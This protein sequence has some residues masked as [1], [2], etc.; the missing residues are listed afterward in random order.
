MQT[1]DAG[2]SVQATCLS[3]LNVCRQH[4]LGGA[5]AGNTGF[6][7]VN[8]AEANVR[9]LVR[10]ILPNETEGGSRFSVR[11]C[12]HTHILF[13]DKL[14]N[15]HFHP[16][17]CICLTPDSSTLYDGENSILF[18][19]RACSF[20]CCQIYACILAGRHSSKHVHALGACCNT[21]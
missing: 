4:P 1:S 18:S 15:A 19:L 14:A 10:G 17:C 8:V 21:W 7:D 3:L 5:Q 2:M 16:Y 12:R 11:H 9:S 20:Q 6:G 13:Y